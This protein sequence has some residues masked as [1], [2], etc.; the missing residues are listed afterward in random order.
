VLAANVIPLLTVVYPVAVTSN[1]IASRGQFGQG[2]VAAGI[3]DRGF[4]LVAPSRIFTVAPVTAILRCGRCA[5]STCV[6]RKAD[7]VSQDRKL[8]NIGVKADVAYTTGVH[9]LKIDGTISATKLNEQFTIGFT[10]P[11]FNSP[12]SPL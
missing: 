9:N 10:D 1:R 5:H 12:D 4:V 6:V 7:S 11:G 8:T 2:V 3:G